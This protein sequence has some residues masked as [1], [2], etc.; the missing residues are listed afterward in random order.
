MFQQSFPVREG[1]IINDI[2]EEESHGGG[3]GGIAM[4]IVRRCWHLA[5]L[6]PG[7]AVRHTAPVQCGT[8]CRRRSYR[9]FAI[10]PSGPDR[11]N[12]VQRAA[13]LS[14]GTGKAQ[15]M[16]RR[17]CCD[18]STAVHVLISSVF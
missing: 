7:T 14:S 5:L 4:Q 10:L 3:I 12:R 8:R 18:L 1:E 9:G 13:L 11:V 6:R 2:N 15:A 16:R 17:A